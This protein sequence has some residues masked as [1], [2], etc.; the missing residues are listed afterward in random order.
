MFCLGAR[1]SILASP[2]LTINLL[3][4]IYNSQS[5]LD[6]AIISLSFLMAERSTP[7]CK[8]CQKQDGI[9]GPLEMCEMVYSSLLLPRVPDPRVRKSPGNHRFPVLF[10]VFNQA[11]TNSHISTVGP[12]ANCTVVEHDRTP[13]GSA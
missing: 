12:P 11:I 6:Q 4:N 1:T 5:I 2:T 7:V 8:V 10:P 13:P 9:D 3:F